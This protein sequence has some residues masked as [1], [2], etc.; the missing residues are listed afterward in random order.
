MAGG[1]CRSALSVGQFVIFLPFHPSVLKPDFDLPLGETKSMGN[2]NPP[3]PG[4]IPVKMKLLF[5]LQNLL[6]RVSRSGSFGLGSCVIRVHW[7][8]ENRR[9]S[10][11]KFGQC[12]SKTI[13]QGESFYPGRSNFKAI[14]K[15]ARAG[16]NKI[17]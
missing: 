2:L 1:W 13:Q 15:E 12:K 16:N 4:Q 8:K 10:D 5:K 17:I 11:Q 14:H 3:P 6:P 9:R 7:K